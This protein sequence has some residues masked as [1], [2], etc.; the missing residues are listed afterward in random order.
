MK[1]RLDVLDAMRYP[2]T[3]MERSWANAHPDASLAM[4]FAVIGAFT[5][6]AAINAFA[7]M[8]FTEGL[9]KK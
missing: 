3:L 1:R 7:A 6:F 8:R 9:S 4:H 5:A 2:L